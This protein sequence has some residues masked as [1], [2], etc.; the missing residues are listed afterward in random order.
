MLLCSYLVVAFYE[1]VHI[2]NTLF[3]LASKAVS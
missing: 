3:T 2:D 1:K